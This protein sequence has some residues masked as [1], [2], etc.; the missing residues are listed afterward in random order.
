MW[1]RLQAKAAL[2]RNRVLILRPAFDLRSGARQSASVR[3]CYLYLD[4]I[5]VIRANIIEIILHGE[6]LRLYL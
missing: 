4:F 6:M 5:F 2:W 1:L 3:N